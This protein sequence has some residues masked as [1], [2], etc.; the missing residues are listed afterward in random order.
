MVFL[1]WR[2]II[3]LLVIFIYKDLKINSWNFKMLEVK[4]LNLILLWNKLFEKYLFGKI[5]FVFFI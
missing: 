5:S 1:L 2:E 3:E 4:W